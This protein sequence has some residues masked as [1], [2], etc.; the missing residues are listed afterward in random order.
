MAAFSV[1]GIVGA[2]STEIGTTAQ[3]I[4]YFLSA[5]KIKYSYGFFFVLSSLPQT[6]KNIAF[7]R[8]PPKLEYISSKV[9]KGS[10]L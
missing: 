10:I 6:K 1:S 3:L 7:I 8:Y 9:D 2:C 5:S 4:F